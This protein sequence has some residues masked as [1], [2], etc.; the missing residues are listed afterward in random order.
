M[1]RLNKTQKMLIYINELEQTIKRISI[2]HNDCYEQ[3]ICEC[4]GE[5]YNY[6]YGSTDLPWN[7]AENVMKYADK[8]KHTD[9][10]LYA[11]IVR[12]DKTQ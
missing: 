5:V 12:L 2:R 8:I 4:C 10:C 3:V 9:D 11:R 7:F 1:S 6:R